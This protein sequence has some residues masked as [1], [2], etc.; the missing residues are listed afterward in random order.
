MTLII[1]EAMKR[2]YCRISEISAFFDL[3][4]FHFGDFLLRLITPQG[5]FPCLS[6]VSATRSRSSSS[7]WGSMAVAVN[8]TARYRA[9]VWNSRSLGLEEQG[10]VSSL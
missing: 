7:N 4:S 8:K 5:V 6:P 1:I 9:L 10:Q 2:I 3:Q